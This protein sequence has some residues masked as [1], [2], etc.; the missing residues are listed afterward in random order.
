[1]QGEM[2]VQCRGIIEIL[3]CVWLQ[4][5]VLYRETRKLHAISEQLCLY[6]HLQLALLNFTLQLYINMLMFCAHFRLQ[7]EYDTPHLK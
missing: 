6:E 3:L 7:L 2:S 5:A 4:F 1:M